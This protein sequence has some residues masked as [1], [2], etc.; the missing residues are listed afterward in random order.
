MTTIDNTNFSNYDYYEEIGKLLKVVTFVKKDDVYD[1]MLSPNNEIYE[2]YF[3]FCQENLRN[4][5]K[6]YD[7]QPSFFYFR[8]DLTVNAHAIVSESNYVIG[9]NKGTI[10]QLYELFSNT[11]IFK[12]KLKEYQVFE[13]F[14][15]VP[16]NHLMFQLSTQFTYYHELGHL[17]QNSPSLVQ[18]LDE[19]YNQELKSKNHKLEFDAD[20]HGANSIAFHVLQYWDKIQAEFKTQE[21]MEKLLAT[22]LASVFCYLSLL[23]R[24][25]KKDIYYAE[26]THPHPL[27]RITYILPTFIDVITKHHSIE[28]VKII[29]ESIR[30]SNELFLENKREDLVGT[31]LDKLFT[32]RDNIQEYVKYLVN[33][34]EKYPNLAVN[35]VHKRHLNDNE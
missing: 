4:Y 10:H 19:N 21:N 25:F 12:Q 14:L 2:Q 34:A 22:C 8:E 30:I 29:K 9:V 26:N 31:Y 3:Q 18:G 5:C 24:S 7:I 16:L 32:E 13:T 28:Q 6:E 33:E 15:D 20:L 27:I 1:F 35:K 23:F 11:N 17:I